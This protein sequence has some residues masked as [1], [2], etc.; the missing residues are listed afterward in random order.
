MEAYGTGD[1]QLYD[2]ATDPG[3]IHDLA[4]KYSDRVDFL[5]KAW[6]AYAET[7]SVIR[8]DTPTAYA[9]P[10]IGRKH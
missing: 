6:G 8:P 7:N 10:V 9:K 1:W 3:E 4:T 2:L 5:A